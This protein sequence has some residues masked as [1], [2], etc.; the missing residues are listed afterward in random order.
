M[1][2]FFQVFDLD[3]E[4]MNMIKP[5]KLAEMLAP[6][7]AQQ[8]KEK[9]EAKGYSVFFTPAILSGIPTNVLV[10]VQLSA[11]KDIKIIFDEIAKSL[12]IRWFEDGK[13]YIPYIKE[14]S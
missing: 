7:T 2:K 11:E 6:N 12:G 10:E 8:L 9:L 13:T 4:E 5:E 1:E 3:L 14:A